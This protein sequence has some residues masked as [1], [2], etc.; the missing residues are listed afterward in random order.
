MTKLE[1]AARQALEALESDE[2]MKK[3]A[4]SKSLREALAEPADEPVAW[5]Y[6]NRPNGLIQAFTNEPPPSLKK[7][8]QPLYTRPQPAVPVGSLRDK[9]YPMAQHQEELNK[10]AEDSVWDGEGP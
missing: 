3:M 7:L 5:L 10:F 4:A 9:V 6:T 8:C 1:Q 2:W